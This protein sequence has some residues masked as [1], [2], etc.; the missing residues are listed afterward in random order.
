MSDT[1]ELVDLEQRL[2]AAL[3]RIGTAL[4]GLAR[5]PAEPDAAATADAPDAV[6]DPAPPAAQPAA[7]ADLP[8]IARLTAA[9]EDER[10]VSAQLEER[11][12]RLKRRGSDEAVALRA[13]LADARAALARLD[14]DVQDL[15]AA[16]DALRDA[17][18]ALRAGAEAGVADAALI[19]RVLQA[20][21]AALAAT[22]ATDAAEAE[23]ILTA[24]SPLL[25]PP[26]PIDGAVPPAQEV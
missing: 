26:A 10:T 24:I 13:E 15:R 23:A 4:E 11:I 14:A 8:D 19:N 3:E 2:T 21:L 6:P 1:S 12:R 18:A 22:R 17:A 20:E 5:L 16:N 25:T 9:L 7:P